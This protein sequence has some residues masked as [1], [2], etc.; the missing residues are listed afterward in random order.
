M[1]VETTGQTSPLTPLLTSGEGECYNKFVVAKTKLTSHWLRKIGVPA[2]LIPGMVFAAGFGWMGWQKIGSNYYANKQ[3]FPDSGMV[4]TI[5]DGDTFELNDGV[6]V[7]LVGIDAPAREIKSTTELSKLILDKKVWLEYDRYPD[8]K[9]SRVL[10]WVWLGC[11]VTPKFLPAN[12]MHL[13]F[14]RSREGLTENPQGCKQGK[15]VQEELLKKGVVKFEVYKD[16]GELKYGGRI[17]PH[18]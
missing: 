16:R 7:R 13:S 12:Y 6:I 8:D 5:T 18:P 4:K 2:V 3:V 15:L 11:E 10:A 1:E 9:Y 14:N 17:K